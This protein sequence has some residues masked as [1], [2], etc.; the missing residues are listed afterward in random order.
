LLF[1][2]PSGSKLI[3]HSSLIFCYKIDFVLIY[4]LCSCIPRTHRAMYVFIKIHSFEGECNLYARPSFEYADARTGITEGERERENKRMDNVAR[5][6]GG[7]TVLK[8]SED[9]RTGRQRMAAAA[10]FIAPQEAGQTLPSHRCHRTDRWTRGY[11]LQ[12]PHRKEIPPLSRSRRNAVHHRRRTPS[13]VDARDAGG[14]V[15]GFFCV[16]HSGRVAHRVGFCLSSLR[17]RPFDRRASNVS[18]R[19]G[20]FGNL[21][22]KEKRKIC[23]WRIT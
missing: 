9:R 13:S 8:P 17:L 7:K 20:H 2:R 15:R 14:E 4:Y 10:R 1:Y 19:R 3:N 21:P 6:I 18:P 22:V 16:P 5:I 12:V 11:A 23:S